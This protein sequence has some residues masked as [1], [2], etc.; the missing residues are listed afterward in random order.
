MNTDTEGP[1]SNKS[2][3]DIPLPQA[4]LARVIAQVRF[5]TFSK[6]ASAESDVALAFGA[7]I[8]DYYPLIDSGHEQMLSISVAGLTPQASQTNLWRFRS[9]DSL[10]QVSLGP[11]FL[12]LD[13]ADY[14]RRSDFTSR[15]EAVWNAFAEVARPPFIERVGIRYV[16]RVDSPE[17]VSQLR[18]L[19]RAE[20]AGAYGL[21][22][23]EA[24][25]RRTLTDIHYEFPDGENF[26]AR[27]GV[28]PPNVQLDPSIQ[29]VDVEAW[30]LDQDSS[31][32]W[33]PGKYAGERLADEIAPLALRPYQFFRWAVKDAFL[34]Q[35][36]G[37]VK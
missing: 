4:P 31:K 15:I 27:F 20:V 19:V 24:V 23:S 21:D 9:A 8:S 3:G 26:I 32:L 29:P 5:P 6:F 18:T 17:L 35:F 14:T 16:N 36:G 12:S 25:L 34:E 28:L 30:V 1:F 2:P 37:Q 33:A 22:S 7:A 13:T 10:W 11:N